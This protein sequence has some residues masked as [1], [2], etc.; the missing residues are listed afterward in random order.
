MLQKLLRLQRDQLLADKLF[1][2]FLFEHWFDV[3]LSGNWH[4]DREN[5]DSVRQED[6]GFFGINNFFNLIPK[7]ND[8]IVFAAAIN[9]VLVRHGQDEG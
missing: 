7:H 4:D 8:T 5:V 3:F 6:N 2:I 9:N 1:D